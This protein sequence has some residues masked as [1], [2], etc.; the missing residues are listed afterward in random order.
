MGTILIVESYLNLGSLYREVLEEEGHRVFVAPTG[1]DAIELASGQ[2]VDVAVVEDALPDFNAEELLHELKRLQPRMQGTVCTKTDFRPQPQTDLCDVSVQKTPDFK[3][4]Q[5]KVNTLL[6]G[7]S[8][9]PS[10]LKEK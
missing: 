4:L 8:T 5:E 1:K 2:Q 7:S 3:I 9:A 10:R 6:Q